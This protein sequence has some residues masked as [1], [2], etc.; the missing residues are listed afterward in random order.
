[1][2]FNQEG[3]TVLPA[4]FAQERLWFFTQL[5]PDLAVY[6]VGATGLPITDV[7]PALFEP[8]FAEVVRRHEAM[9][10]SL[11]VRDGHL[12]QVIHPRVPIVIARSDLRGVPAEEKEAALAEAAL[13]DAA[14]P[15]PLDRA[16]LWRVRQVYLDDSSWTWVITVHHVAFDGTSVA[17]LLDE[18]HEYYLAHYENRPPRW[19]ELAVQYG[20]FAEWQR[21]RWDDGEFEGQVAYWRDRLAE[22]PAPLVLGGRLPDPAVPRHHGGALEFSLSREVV[23]DVARFAASRGTTSF[24]VLLAA[25]KVLVMRMSGQRDV[26]VG[27]PVAGR[28]RAELRPLIGMFVNTVVLRTDT[29]PEADFAEVVDRVRAGFLDALDHQDVPYE[30]LVEIAAPDRADGGGSPLHQIVF[31]LLP[32][33]YNRQVRNGTAK[34]D[35]LFD[36]AEK[37]GEI[38]GWLEYSLALF[39]EPWAQNLLTRF[40]HLLGGL[41]AEPGVPVGRVGVVDGKEHDRLVEAGR[42]PVPLALAEPLVTEAFARVAATCTDTVAVADSA[43]R[44]L[45]YAE[46]DRRAGRLAGHLRTVAAVGPDTPV[47]LLL[48]TDV[49][50]A[51]AVLAVLKAGGAYLPLDREH[52]GERLRY[53]LGD[54]GAVAVITTPALAGRLPETGLP[55]IDVTARPEHPEPP[56]GAVPDPG[57]LAYVVYTSGS[58]GRP[59]GVGVPH[60]Q[61]MAYVGG[62]TALLGLEAGRSFSLLQSL[63]FDFG[64]TTFF[65]ALL[66]GGTLH[67][68]SANRAADAAWVSAHL[69]REGIDYLKITPSHLAALR[70]GD[71]DPAALLP[72]RTLILGGEASR[73]EWV[74]ELRRHC[75]VVNHYGPTETTVGVLALPAD[76]EPADAGALTPIGWPMAQAQAYV[77]DEHLQFVPDGVVG[78]LYVGGAGV[79]RGYLGR[80]GATA[81]AFLPHPFVPGERLYRTGDRVRRLA[82]GAVEFLGRADD[83]LK[84]RGFRVEPGEVQAAIAGHPGVEDCVVLPYGDGDDT[85]LVAYVVGTADHA[86]IRER[87]AGHLPDYMIPSAFVGLPE[88]PLLA[89][90]K[91]NRAALPV[92]EADTAA[93]EPP[94]GETEEMVAALFGHLLGVEHVSRNSGFFALGG[95]S[96]LAIK[97]MSRMRAAFGVGMPL[98]TVFE[99]PTPAELAAAVEAGLRKRSDQL[100]PVEPI[101]RTGTLLA[102]YGQRRLWFLDRLEQGSAVYNTPIHLRVHGEFSTTLFKQAVTA[103]VARHEVLRTRL[104]E[105]DDDLA[106]VI[107]ADPVVPYREINSPMPEAKARELLAAEAAKRFDLTTK[108]PIRVMVVKLAETDHL[109]LITLH[110]VANDAWSA[111]LLQRELSELY[112]AL[113]ENRPAELPELP[114]QYADFAAWQRRMIAG[115]LRDSQLGYWRKRLADM[116][117]RLE[118][119]TDRPRPAARGHAGSQVPLRIPSAV[120]E[121]LRGLGADENATLYMTL[122]AGFVILLSRY[123]GEEDVV[124]GTP[125][126][127]RPRPELESL[128]GFFLNTLV[129][130]TDSSGDPSFRDLLKRVRDTTLEAYANQDVPFEALIEDLQPRRDLGGTPLVQVL[131]SLEND[132]RPT[133]STGGTRFTWE[134]FGTT[135]AKFDVTLYLWRRPGALA[136]AVEFRTDIFDTATMSRFAAHYTALLEAAATEPD[137]P[138]SRLRMLTDEDSASIE[139]WNSTAVDHPGGTL[140]ALVA[141]QAAATPHAAALLDGD[142]WLTYAQFTARV[143]TLA[144]RLRQLGVGLGDVV[145]VCLDRGPAEVVAVHAVQ[146]A[147]AA[148]LP[149]EPTD[150]DAR[151]TYMIGDTGAKLVITDTAGATRFGNPLNLDTLDLAAH[152]KPDP[153]IGAIPEDAPAYVIYT[154]G[155]TGNPKGVQ[156]SH[157][158]IVNRLTWMQNTFQLTPGDRVLHKTPY[159][160]DVSVWELFWPLLTGAALAVAPPGTHR[161][162]TALAD[163]VNTHHI[164]TI[165]FVPPML[166]ALLD[167]PRLHLPTLQRV[168]CSGEALPTTLA[169]RFHTTLPGIALH[170]LYGPTE[171]AVDVTWHH[172]TPGQTH[173]PIGTPVDNTSIEILDPTGA[174]TPIGTPG[175]LCIGGIQL[176][177]AYLNRPALTA[178]RFTPNPYGPPAS[179]LYHT[180]D[181]ARWLPDGSIEYLGRMDHQIK[182]RGMRVELGEI[183]HALATHPAIRTA[184]LTAGTTAAGTVLN[185][186]LIPADPGDPPAV[187]GIRDHLRERLPEHMIPSTYT[188]LPELPLTATGKIRRNALPAPA[189]E[190]PSGEYVAP[191]SP[192]EARLTAIW[193]QILGVERVGIH[194]DFFELGGHSLLALRLAM[195]LRAE[196]GR[197]VPVATVIAAPTVERLAEAMYDDTPSLESQGRVVPLRTTGDRPPM[198]FIHALGG[199]VFRYQPLARYLGDDQPVYAIPA[200]GLTEG[201][202]PHATLEEMAQVYAGYIRATRPEGPY[203]IGGFCIGGNISLE[204]A[205]QLRAE[206]A[207]VPLVLLAWSD[208]DEPVI[209]SS[210]EDDR[211]LMVH[212]L[213]GSLNT[214]DPRDLAE[215]D[216]EEQLLAIVGAATKEG[217]LRS[218]AADLEQMRRYVN[219]FRANAHAV[220][221]YRH[222]PYDGYAVLLI[223][224]DDGADADEDY[225]WRKVVPRLETGLIPGAR[226]S[227]LYEPLVA[228]TATETRRWMDRGLGHPTTGN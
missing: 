82:S 107:H 162:T 190:G 144:H 91:V 209:R 46:L 86:G 132:E 99:H 109:L 81:A 77:L 184:T 126:A 225:G 128:I 173:T 84:I 223:P 103:L 65:G 15:I 110:H 78:E 62:L 154:S 36:L 51:V 28:G 133:V 54:A 50:L 94:R 115:E 2:D 222:E 207:E 108:P 74:R 56:A 70:A 203:V 208:A 59:K 47:A 41:L 4:S 134:P 196:F 148:Y 193:E 34:T 48:D 90:G 118:L 121:R 219:V 26:I 64:V 88:L 221:W 151:L 127:H 131:F 181:L 145:A 27:S 45:T 24:V 198:F 170:N 23:A 18:M 66:S 122:L 13:A 100:P 69:R 42:P 95:H 16:P 217:S 35:L 141:A 1:M 5:V 38:T 205:R 213:A 159:T 150:P 180:G 43:G 138:I 123:T 80:P 218:D 114:V 188:F 37:D 226:F 113:R 111:V 167:D 191:R 9:R 22:L 29:D 149:L 8:A 61:L 105:E 224:E 211:S 97:L 67:L 93:D 152:P 147:G 3:E 212:A 155:S 143:N 7:H 89:H 204:V 20:D 57:D 165:H 210:L 215:M 112:G 220:G 60:R 174:R 216:V 171:A 85:R 125:S 156:I 117:E 192:V 120:V 177:H 98:R 17:N 53:V 71:P 106:L 199:Q 185:A 76:A 227:A 228:K 96:L 214:L 146:A 166:D 189:A 11:E 40:H 101:P 164:T 142:T 21:G 10:T 55:V 169:D 160:F 116:P 136:G 194:D 14:E 92:P 12:V 75:Q 52:P 153:G 73:W 179:R 79:S 178:E 135:T 206:G 68:V 176:A 139:R 140:P 158:A 58:T 102:S 6:N 161:D 83:Q 195:R 201:D 87:L 163:L 200:H 157:R 187:A 39:D 19:P 183:E 186:Y 30:K 72:R 25:L 49:D 182:I 63:T 119:P 44:R 137:L 129:L 130:R 32:Q 33:S 175:E 168:I 202:E 197:E 104:A 31:N 172:C 124:V